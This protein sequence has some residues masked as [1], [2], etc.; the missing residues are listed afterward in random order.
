MGPLA[1]VTVLVLAGW[2]ALN[3]A[4][5]AW[6]YIVAVLGFE[7]WLLSRMRSASGAAVA[8]GEAPYD[9]SEEEAKLVGRYRF[10]FAYPVIAKQ[11]SSVLAAIG[12]T[13]LGL[14][15]WLTY[16]LAFVQAALIGLNIF[17]V[18]SLTR[19]VA[20]VMAL[21]LSASRGNREALRLLEV[22]DAA[23]KKIRAANRGQSPV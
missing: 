9:F 8:A 21:S 7:M 10:Y 23:W 11:A 20:P 12:L 6:L 16:K 3:P 15:P 22:H 17:V 14:A 2:A 18:A 1:S 13:T 19:R 4:P 5:M